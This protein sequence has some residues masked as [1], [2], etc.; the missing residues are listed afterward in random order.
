[1]STTGT[2]DRAALPTDLLGVLEM[3]IIGIYGLPQKQNK[4]L[5]MKRRRWTPFVTVSVGSDTWKSR[6]TTAHALAGRSSQEKRETEDWTAPRPAS[7]KQEDHFDDDELTDPT[8]R[9]G[10]DLFWHC[11]PVPVYGATQ[12]WDLV[13]T[14]FDNALT[15]NTVIGTLDIETGVLIRDWYL[16]TGGLRP[17]VSQKLEQFTDDDWASRLRNPSTSS[18]PGSHFDPLVQ[19]DF[20]VEPYRFQ[21]LVL[22][23]QDI[24]CNPIMSQSLTTKRRYDSSPSFGSAPAGLAVPFLTLSSDYVDSDPQTDTLDSSLADDVSEVSDASDWDDLSDFS[25]PPEKR[26]FGIRRPLYVERDF[27]LKTS[28]GVDDIDGGA[29]R[30]RIKFAFNPYKN[31]LRNLII[32]LLYGTTVL[33]NSITDSLPNSPTLRPASRSASRPASPAGLRSASPAGSRSASPSRMKRVASDLSS[34]LSKVGLGK[35]QERDP[36]LPISNHTFKAYIGGLTA[37]ASA[38]PRS[39]SKSPGVSRTPSPSPAKQPAEADA[40]PAVRT[41]SLTS[42]ESMTD[43]SASVSRVDIML[44]M[45]YLDMA[46]RMDT[47][48]LDRLF[49]ERDR[50]PI[51]EV[52]NAMESEEWLPVP[53]PSPEQQMEMI[54]QHTEEMTHKHAKSTFEPLDVAEKCPLCKLSWPT[55]P[56]MVH[57]R[58]ADMLPRRAKLDHVLV[59]ASLDYPSLARKSFWRMGD[60]LTTEAA[61]RKWFSRWIGRFGLGTYGVGANDAY[62]LVQNRETGRL[63]E[64]LIPLTIR[65]GIRLLYQGSGVRRVIDTQRVQRIFQNMSVKQGMKYDQ[66][67]PKVQRRIHHFVAEYSLDLSEMEKPV[68]EFQTFNEF[69]SRKLRPGSRVCAFPD[70]LGRIVS[71][72]D[73]RLTVHNTME[74]AKEVWIKGKSFSVANL[75]ANP[76]MGKLFEDCSLAIHRLAPQDYHRYHSPVDGKVVSITSHPGSYY[77]VNP[78][79]VRSTVAVYSDNVREVLYIDSPQ[80]GLVAFVAVGAMLV[81]SNQFTV[82][83]GDQVKRA[84]E[85][86]FFKFGGSTCL[87]LI[88]KGRCKYDDDLVSNSRRALETLVRTGDGIGS[89]CQHT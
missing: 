40:V 56:G 27:H 87:L 3:E 33:Q 77:T 20:S 86:G 41:S 70:D 29:I 45:F 84:D 67:G 83:V 85:L 64:E 4:I 30:V 48:G 36:R 11:P 78:M 55:P 62:I 75:L 49:G 28:P 34:A 42:I 71:A 57:Q 24:V 66:T 8:R 19:Q 21:D 25:V 51:D 31:L 12:H 63:E 9:M 13:L 2:K 26:I 22:G 73:C 43:D 14:A 7:M 79:A 58:S 81:G 37:D 88:Q 38:P 61:G 60:F 16:G 54:K 44:I 17:A 74:S 68:R 72:A 1:M 52:V 50:I 32:S 80:F 47:V 35:K 53:L 46:H 69:F 39:A 18:N 89:L 65:L 23:V 10:A 76:E 59:C 6:V 5:G 15:G 82:K